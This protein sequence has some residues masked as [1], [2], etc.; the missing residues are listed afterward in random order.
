ML[1]RWFVAVNQNAQ[2]RKG[3][4]RLE[5]VKLIVVKVHAWAGGMGKSAAGRDCLALHGGSMT[6]EIFFWDSPRNFSGLM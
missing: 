1:V 6:K 4:R 3:K 2:R 5:W